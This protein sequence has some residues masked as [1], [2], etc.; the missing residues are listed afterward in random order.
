MTDKQKII[1]YQ[2]LIENLS[3]LSQEK[4]TGT[5]FITTM[6]NHSARFS[7]YE[8][9]ITSCHFGPKKNYDAIP[10]IKQID[11]CRFKFADGIFDDMHDIG[12]P[13]NSDVFDMLASYTD[14]EAV[15]SI[16]KHDNLYHHE[17]EI[18]K[19][20]ADYIGP[21]ATMICHELFD[22]KKNFSSEELKQIIGELSMEV[23][24][25]EK[26]AEFKN[27]ALQILQIK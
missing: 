4:R 5:A 1:D 8:G 11:K 15:K 9:N 3:K 27:K 19:L 16:E 20:L 2:E 25:M 7:F 12:L 22:G 14:N 24:D 10:L 23:D 21:F 13:N 17:K 26:R 18:A 6:D